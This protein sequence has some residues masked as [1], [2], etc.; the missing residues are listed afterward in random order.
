MGGEGVFRLL[1]DFPDRFAGAVSAAG[2]TL[3][4]GADRIARTPLWIAVGAEDFDVVGSNRAIYNS[5]IDAGGS[6]VKYSEYQGFGHVGGIEE[7]RGEPQILQWL[8]SQNRSTAI[9]KKT[10]CR[11]NN[12]GTSPKFSIIDGNLR[13]TSSFPAG[14]VIKMFNLNGRLLLETDKQYGLLRLPAGASGR[15]IVWKASNAGH[16]VTGSA[17]LYNLH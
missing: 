9:V 16:T 15:T 14:T 6:A 3:D 4:T 12:F 7:A 17:L 2:Y 11:N 10:V 5:I 13:I 8:L 1:L